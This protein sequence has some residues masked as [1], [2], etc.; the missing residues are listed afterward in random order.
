M[1]IAKID[2]REFEHLE[3]LISVDFKTQNKFY[4]QIKYFTHEIFLVHFGIHE[5]N[6]S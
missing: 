6:F 4:V 1:K 2:G 5:W 3:K